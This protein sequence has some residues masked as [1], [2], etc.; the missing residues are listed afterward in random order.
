MMKFGKA[1]FARFGWF[2]HKDA[3]LDQFDLRL[4]RIGSRERRH[5]ARPVLFRNLHS[6]LAA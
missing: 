5:Q 6:P 3:E 1:L 4:L 2:T